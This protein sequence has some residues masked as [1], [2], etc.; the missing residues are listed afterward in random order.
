MGLFYFI[1]S[2]A[3]IESMGIELPTDME[4]KEYKDL[5]T[6]RYTQSA[7]NCWFAGGLYVLLLALSLCQ[8]FTNRAI[9]SHEKAK[10]EEMKKLKRQGKETK[11]E[12]RKRKHK[13]KKTV[14][15]G[16]GDEGNQRN[17]GW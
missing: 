7:L 6:E 2:E 13:D 17:K 9:K 3:L 15:Q 10:E 1:E 16:W 8:F 4:E 12:S 14:N 11:E 5:V